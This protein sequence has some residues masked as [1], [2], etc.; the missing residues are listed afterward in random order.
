MEQKCIGK[1]YIKKNQQTKTSDEYIKIEFDNLNRI[2]L[3][4]ERCYFFFRLLSDHFI[5]LGLELGTI[6]LYLFWL[7]SFKLLSIAILH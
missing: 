6:F 7:F 4:E 2:K 5:H 1:K 3:A